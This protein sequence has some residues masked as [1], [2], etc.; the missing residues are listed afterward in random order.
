MT[1]ELETDSEEWISKS[2][3]K[4]EDAQMQALGK[5]LL[6]LSKAKIEEFPVSETLRD[7]LL[8]YKRIRS[9]EAQRRHVKRVG[10]L[11]REHDVDQVAL[12][13]DRVDPSSS[14]SM[15]ATKSAQRWCERLIQD[16]KPVLT[17]LIERYPDIPRQNLGQLLR[18]V[19]AEQ[20][21]LGDAAPDAKPS[22]SQ[23]E[24]LRLLRQC[25]VQNS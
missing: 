8:E 7:A 12:A 17:E 15:Q 14:L 24:M 23:R 21:K 3:A 20:K 6:E 16:G 18:K 1:D 13:L 4:R 9:H 25:I 19:R 11:L 5:R 2:Q 22:A 10:R